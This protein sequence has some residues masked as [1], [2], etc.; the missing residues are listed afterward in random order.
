MSQGCTYVHLDAVLLSCECYL[1]GRRGPRER[2]TYILI[3]SPRLQSRLFQQDI[4]VPVIQMNYR[5]IC[6]VS[7]L[8][9]SM[10][11]YSGY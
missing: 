10:K 8:L 11:Q 9:E 6:F 7:R 2:G 5:E 3:G 4:D 1:H